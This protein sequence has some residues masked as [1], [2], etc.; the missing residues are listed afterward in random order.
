MAVSLELLT[1]EA[2]VDYSRSD[3]KDRVLFDHRDLN[4]SY[5]RVQ[6]YPGGVYDTDIFG[7]PLVDRCICGKIRQPSPEPCPNCGARVFTKDEALRRFARIEFPFYY[8]NDLRFDIF[9]ELFN[10]IFKDTKI[11]LD[12]MG[13]DL[14]R[15]GYSAT[16]GGRKLGIKV[17]DSC[18]F[19]YEP[20][21]KE[22][23]ISEFITDEAKC[24]YEGIMDIVKKYFPE[25]LPEYMKLINHYYLVQPAVMRP[26]TLGV[27]DGKKVMG[28]H[29]LSVWCGILMRLCCVEAKK[30]NDLNYEEVMSRF[31][32][33]GERVR[34][35][36]LLRA[37]INTGKKE[38]TELLNTSK[39]NLARELYSVRTKNSARCPIVPSTTL[40]IDE[41]GVPTHIAYEMCREGF[42]TYLQQELNFSYDEARKAT[43][44]EADNEETQRLFKEYAEKQIV[45]ETNT[46]W[47]VKV[48]N[49]CVIGN[50]E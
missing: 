21:K 34:Y 24:S 4:L 15:G 12:F 26:F 25:R 14:K 8:L 50:P 32:T 28:S 33:P 38:A 16:R 43:K 39:E 49:P 29:K 9:I 31:K 13:D 19:N 10:D 36:A 18:Q 46:H 44:L 7:S 23:V 3:G 42:M 5:D 30:S 17:F 41:L 20:K 48:I 11:A 45:L 35:T 37:L 2:I 22:L 6:P 40:G 47:Y 1:D 27:K